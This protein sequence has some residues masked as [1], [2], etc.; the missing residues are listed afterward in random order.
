MKDTSVL[1]YL[2]LEEVADNEGHVN[3]CYLELEVADNEGY[4][5]PLLL[6]TGRNSR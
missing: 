5:N 1:C 2:K 4:V 3:P 6:K